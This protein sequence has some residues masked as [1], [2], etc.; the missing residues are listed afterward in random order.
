[1]AR[2]APSR[3]SEAPPRTGP[4]LACALLLLGSLLAGCRAQAAEAPTAIAAVVD[5]SAIPDTTVSSTDPR[6]TLV[7]GIY[8]YGGQPFEGFIEER[9]S[10]GA[11]KARGSYYRGMLHGTTTTFYPDGQPRDTRSY[12]ASLAYG[13]HAG[14]WNDGS[15]RFDFFYVDDKRE[16]VQRQ[17]YRSGAPYTALTFHDDKEQGMQR[18]WRENGRP[19]INYEAKDGVRYGLQ[20]SALCF[21]LEDGVIP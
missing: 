8:V 15:M 2:R 7:N 1:M 13:R 20:K 18:A 11:L 4:V 19:Y 16:G 12:R 10:S 14:Y 5:V 17:W 6:L 21:T 3:S 9:Y